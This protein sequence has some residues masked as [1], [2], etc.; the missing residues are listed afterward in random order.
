MKVQMD[1]C[2]STI[3]FI[4]RAYYE[5]YPGKCKIIGYCTV[6]GVLQTWA[7]SCAWCLYAIIA[8]I[9]LSAFLC[10]PKHTVVGLAPSPAS[11]ADIRLI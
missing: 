8:E 6:T 2:A 4:V 1:V 7:S 11:F 10:S 9:L 5:K 3:A